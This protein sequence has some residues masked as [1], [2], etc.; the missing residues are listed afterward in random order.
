MNT[1]Q[2]IEKIE[3]VRQQLVHAAEHE[4]LSSD[5]IQRISRCLDHLLNK[6]DRIAEKY[7]KT[8]N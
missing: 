8:S 1:Q 2:L 3:Y 4:S 6:Y 5:R 7:G